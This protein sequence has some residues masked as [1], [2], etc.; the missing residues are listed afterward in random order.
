MFNSNWYN[1]LAK[2]FL[3]PPSFVFRPVWTVLYVFI[4]T[5]FVLYAIKHSNFSKFKGYLY[6]WLQ[7][8]LNILWS[9]LFFYFHRIKLALICIV[10]MDVF[11]FLTIKEFYKTSKP[12]SL[13]LVPY[14]LWILFATYLNFGY[15]GLN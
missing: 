2:P 1:S 3:N 5:S 6:F 7:M 9:P 15:V 12:A 11:V 10:L 13:L 8:V 14:F 4:I